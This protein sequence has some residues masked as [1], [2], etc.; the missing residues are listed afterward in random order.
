MVLLVAGIIEFGW[1]ITQTLNVS[2]AAR[3]ASRYGASV[4]EALDL[5]PGT[6]A[7]PAA[8]SF[9]LE[10]LQGAGM[11]CGD[12]CSVTARVEVSPF[13]TVIVDITT[14]YEPLFGIVTIPQAVQYSF[15]TAVEAQ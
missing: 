11:A 5:A 7:I 13:E 8:E 10:I 14:P 12:G 6:L 1:F 3:D 4:Y 2:R 9:A 15:M